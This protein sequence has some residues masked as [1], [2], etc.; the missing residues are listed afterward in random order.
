MNGLE[1]YLGMTKQNHRE[2]LWRRIRQRLPTLPRLAIG[3]ALLGPNPSFDIALAEKHGILRRNIVSVD[4]SRAASKAQQREGVSTITGRMG[5]ALASWSA[6]GDRFDFLMLDSCSNLSVTDELLYQCSAALNPGAAVYIN[7]QRGRE[8]G[9]HLGTLD[10]MREMA[11]SLTWHES[12]GFD[13]SKHR[14]GI[15]FAGLLSL[16]TSQRIN[17]MEVAVAGGF[18]PPTREHFE[19]GMV[20]ILD[21]TIKFMQPEFASYRTESISKSGN[22][23]P[24][25]MDSVV[26]KWPFQAGKDTQP[27]STHPVKRSVAACKANRTKRGWRR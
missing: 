22:R 5:D 11:Q 2:W 4:V 24:I 15:L 13:P 27:I 7:M 16:F 6:N 21:K 25:Y 17:W 14:G 1:E 12:L 23:S 3:A 26:L 9:E 18:A 20:R 8:V 10:W 19:R